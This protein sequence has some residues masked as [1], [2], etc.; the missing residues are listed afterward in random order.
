MMSHS[1]V[2]PQGGLADL[3][4]CQAFL[5]PLTGHRINKPTTQQTNKSTDQQTN[6]PTI[7]QTNTQRNNEITT[8]QSQIRSGQLNIKKSTQNY[9]KICA[10]APGQSLPQE[11]T[12]S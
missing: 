10:K 6:R 8:N 1:H 4:T 3:Q 9:I 5:S 7:S 2:P 12:R 11:P